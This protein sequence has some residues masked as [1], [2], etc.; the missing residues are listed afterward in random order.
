MGSQVKGQRTLVVMTNGDVYYASQSDAAHIADMMATGHPD[1]RVR[2]ID[3]KSR[4]KVVINVAH[5]SSLV[6]EASHA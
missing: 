1:N 6:E 5:V 3:L 2:F 4:S